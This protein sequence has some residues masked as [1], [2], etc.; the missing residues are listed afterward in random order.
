M[1]NECI[2]SI[3]MLQLKYDSLQG[4]NIVVIDEH[5]FNLVVEELG[6]IAFL[7]WKQKVTLTQ[8]VYFYREETKC[9]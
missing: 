8:F 7:T 4:R 3:T 6:V 2:S 1:A 9:M 5:P